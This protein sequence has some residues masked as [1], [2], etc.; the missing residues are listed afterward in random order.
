MGRVSEAVGTAG[1]FQPQASLA[2]A[3][4][5]QGGWYHRPIKGSGNMK[6]DIN[7]GNINPLL[8]YL[9]A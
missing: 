8:V 7:F 1:R 3:V 9:D 5:L 4:G 6:G 2:M